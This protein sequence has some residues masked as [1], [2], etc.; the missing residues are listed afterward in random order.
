[1]T[2]FIFIFIPGGPISFFVPP[3]CATSTGIGSNC[4]ISALLCDIL[5][6]CQ[7][8]GS[9]VNDNTTLYGYICKC[10]VG[11]NGTQCQYDYRPCQPNTCWNNGIF[12]KNKLIN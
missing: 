5:K 3:T 11:F 12:N 1:M 8:N 4:S 2:I 7:N 6:P 10:L 9:C